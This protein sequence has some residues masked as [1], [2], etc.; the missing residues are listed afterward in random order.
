LPGEKLIGFTGKIYAMLC[1]FASERCNQNQE[2]KHESSQG[3]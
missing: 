2:V 3:S 1:L